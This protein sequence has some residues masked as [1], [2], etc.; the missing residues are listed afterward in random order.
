MATA[1]PAKGCCTKMTFQVVQRVIKH[2]L[3]CKFNLKA[4]VSI[5]QAAIHICACC[6]AE[7]S[8]FVSMVSNAFNVCSARNVKLIRAYAGTRNEVRAIGCFQIMSTPSQP[9]NVRRTE[10]QKLQRMIHI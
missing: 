10:G 8:C 9:G 5:D 3:D 1:P 4:K 2:F 7:T 6:Q